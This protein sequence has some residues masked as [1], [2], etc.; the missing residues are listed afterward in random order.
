MVVDLSSLTK[1][2]RGPIVLFLGA[3]S[4]V[5]DGLPSTND[6]AVRVRD[7]LVE[8]GVSKGPASLPLFLEEPDGERLMF[9]LRELWDLYSPDDFWLTFLYHALVASTAQVVDTPSLGVDGIRSQLIDRLLQREVPLYVLTTNWDTSLDR[10]V[11]NLA[12]GGA[13]NLT[14]HDYGLRPVGT[15]LMKEFSGERPIHLLKLNGSPR[16][17]ICHECGRMSVVPVWP[18][19][20]GPDRAS[21]DGESWTWGEWLALRPLFRHRLLTP[22]TEPIWSNPHIAVLCRACWKWTERLMVLPTEGHARNSLINS[23]FIP[24]PQGD[25]SWPFHLYRQAAS[26]MRIAQEFFFVG[27]SLPR[28][29]SAIRLL[30]SSSLEHN[31]FVNRG[32]SS[33]YVVSRDTGIPITRQNFER[34]LSRHSLIFSNDGIENFLENSLGG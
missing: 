4:G 6:V 20:D 32:N 30:L 3:G 14:E 31:P 33:I 15:D 10:I 2:T 34:D 1:R 5:A 24:A 21:L 16:W 26:A 7:R 9:L 25:A 23:A 28:Y 29:D 18:Q 22:T 27:Y 17:F 12:F 13:R 8:I 19:G 11:I